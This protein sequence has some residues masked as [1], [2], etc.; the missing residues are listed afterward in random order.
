MAI[1]HAEKCIQAARLAYEGTAFDE[2]HMLCRR[3][4]Q[5]CRQAIVGRTQTPQFMRRVD[6]LT[7]ASIELQTDLQYARRGGFW[8]GKFE[9]VQ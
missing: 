7:A 2:A 5:L 1:E 4:T 8:S 3:A 9:V 6:A